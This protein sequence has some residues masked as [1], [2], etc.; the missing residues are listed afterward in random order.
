MYRGVL[1]R[2]VLAHLS[3]AAKG[4]CSKE[5]RNLVMEA[6]KAWPTT[7]E[8]VRDYLQQC[9]GEARSLVNHVHYPKEEGTMADQVNYAVVLVLD[10][11]KLSEEAEQKYIHCFI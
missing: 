3:L 2:S 9:T 11:L 8:L 7:D 4:H 5:A 10:Q 1:P 6:F